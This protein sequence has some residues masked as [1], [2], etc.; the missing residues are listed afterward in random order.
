[1]KGANLMRYVLGIDSGGTK[2][3]VTA[4]AL[5]GTHLA[6][7]QGPPA[8]HYR[9]TAEQ[10]RLHIDENIE[11]CLSRFNGKRE[12]CACIV[13]GTSGIDHPHDQIT[14]N[15]IYAGLQGFHCQTVCVNDAVIAHYAA[16]GGVGVL[17]ISGTGSVA[18]GRNA[19]GEEARCGGWPPVIFG[20]EGSGLWIGYMALNHLSKVFDGRLPPSLLSE[21]LQKIL[22]ISGGEGLIA[23]CIEIEHMRWADPGLSAEVNA[24]AGE[25]DEYAVGILREAARHTFALGDSIVRRLGFDKKEEA[26]RVGVWGSAII[27]SP[28]HFT[29]LKEAFEMKYPTAKVLVSNK[30]ASE[31]ACSMALRILRSGE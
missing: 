4:Q 12:G 2:Y 9:M 7:I 20:D 5:D 15:N 10:A 24:I 28:L 14:V 26:F 1:M 6:Q 25:G 8:L 13:C 3:L 21:R 19:A 30:D 22:G 16:T 18:F 29:Y 31:A 17:I 23:V 11:A 27:K